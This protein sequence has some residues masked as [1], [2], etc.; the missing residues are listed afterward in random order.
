MVLAQ[1]TSP[2]PINPLCALDPASYATEIL[3]DNWN[4]DLSSN[5]VYGS[6]LS[7]Y[8]TSVDMTADGQKDPFRPG[9][10]GG[11]WQNPNSSLIQTGVPGWVAN[12]WW[13][14]SATSVTKV[15]FSSGMAPIIANLGQPISILG[16]TVSAI[17]I[18]PLGTIGIGN[19]AVSSVSPRLDAYSA[20]IVSTSSSYIRYGWVNVNGR[21]A[22]NKRVYAIEFS[23]FL[24]NSS[25]G[26]SIS[27]QYLIW[28]D[29]YVQ[30]LYQTDHTRLSEYANSSA[31]IGYRTNKIVFQQNPTKVFL[32]D[33]V[34]TDLWAN[35]KFRPGWVAFDPSGVAGDPNPVAFTQPA[36][37]LVGS[38]NN[39]STRTLD[40]VF[41]HQYANQMIVS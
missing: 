34:G 11:D 15:A 24:A 7:Q 28:D 12:H 23:N 32:I 18:T 21:S 37:A 4:S 5:L 30:I 39:G 9:A 2:S 26:P 31:F 38:R 27:F 14:Q 13:S 3:W 35:G 22:H 40:I 29:G 16:Q 20:K 19:N 25:T 1:T 6:Y 36:H 41:C 10:W 8:F 17:T 33:P